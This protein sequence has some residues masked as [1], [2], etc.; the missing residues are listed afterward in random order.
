MLPRQPDMLSHRTRGD[1]R[2]MD[3]TLTFVILLVSN[4]YHNFLKILF[5]DM[6]SLK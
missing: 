2:E 1:I 6:G 4:E 3:L 5:G